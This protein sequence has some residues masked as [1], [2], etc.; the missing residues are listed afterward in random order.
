MSFYVID[1]PSGTRPAPSPSLTQGAILQ[2]IRVP[3]YAGRAQ[4]GLLITARCDIEH[5]RSDSLTFLPVVPLTHWLLFDG[6]LSILL[7]QVSKHRQTAQQL[8]RKLDANLSKVIDLD[9]DD[10]QN[11]LRRFTDA[12]D[13]LDKPTLNL[14]RNTLVD[15]A[16]LRAA[17]L[18]CAGD[19]DATQKVLQEAGPVS[20]LYKR[21]WSQKLDELLS[22][23][24]L[25]AHFLPTIDMLETTED[26][27]GYV[28]LFRHVISVP[29]LVA[30]YLARGVWSETIQRNPDLG[31]KLAAYLDISPKRFIAIISN[32]QSPYLEYIVQRFVQTFSR[33]GSPDF[34][35]QYRDHVKK[36]CEGL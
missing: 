16:T 34:T 15:L 29:G 36:T 28:V 27:S 2:H 25:D 1:R 24:I 18:Q 4:H 23:K 31:S 7:S 3:R 8:L 14:L 6:A 9:D 21:L 35:P 22:D 12:R 32:I 19:I 10:W 11:S 33:I 20:S 17:Y 30:P 5:V 26:T 13:D